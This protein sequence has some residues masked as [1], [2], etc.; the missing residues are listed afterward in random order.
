MVFKKYSQNQ[1]FLLPPNY[2]DFLGESHEAV[3]LNEFMREMDM[4]AMENSYNN[5][6]GGRAA[7]HPGMLTTLLVYA[8]MN[9]IFSSRKIARSLKQDLAFMYLAGNLQPDFRTLARFRKEKSLL[10]EE[11]FTKIVHKAH[12]MGFV[13]FGICSL[14]GTKIYANASKER[15]IIKELIQK[16]NDTDE[17][18]DALYGDKEDDQDPDLK[19]RAGREKKKKSLKRVNT[20]DPDS[21]LMQM[22]RKDFA[23]GY[24]VQNIT[25]N[26]IILS[27]S[28][29]NTSADQSTLVPS[30]LK[31]Q[32]THQTPRILLADKG[33]SSEKNYTFCEESSIDAYIPTN[34]QKVDLSKYTYNP[35]E[36][37]YTDQQGRLYKFKQNYGRRDGKNLRGVRNRKHYHDEY[38]STCYEY[39]DENT[40][41]KK[42]LS[43]SRGWQ[44]HVE[45]Q[46]EKLS[47][48]EG[49]SIYK[50]RMHD[51]EGVFANIKRNLN[52]TRFNLRGFAG[53]TAEWTLISLAHNLKKLLHPAC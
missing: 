25:E 38:K 50:K 24:N 46:K 28:V 30:V 45:K 11:V 7:Y 42:Y 4:T 34:H 3:I 17:A 41:K 27:S 15:N 8:Y 13:S 36:D 43:V 48:E 33:Y 26:G 16:A 19:T 22:K 31:L 2:A 1:S 10:L 20:T 21:Q 53:V 12:E 39:T 6:T 14:D 47:T 44:R 35:T 23:N 37:T 40:H 29:F 18:E 52:F 9:G 49:R 5:T 51:V 32:S